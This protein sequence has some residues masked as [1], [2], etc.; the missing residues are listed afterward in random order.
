MGEYLS[1]PKTDKESED[2]EGLGVH[3]GASAM[4]GWRVS[5]EDAH[6]A[7]PVF[8]AARG[9]SL[10]A[11]FDGHGGGAVSKIVAEKLPDM[12]RK[13]QKFKEGQYA[14]ALVACFR[15][16]DAY[17][18]STLGRSHV[19]EVSVQLEEEHIKKLS[20]KER[21]EL[22]LE[23]DND[24]MAEMDEDDDQ[25][26]MAE[27]DEEDEQEAHVMLSG[28]VQSD[29]AMDDGSMD[30]MGVDDDG[31]SPDGIGCTA[32]VAL[33]ERPGVDAAWR[34]YVANCGD[35]R[36]VLCDRAGRAIP[37]SKDHKPTHKAERARIEAAGGVVTW[38]GRIDGNLNLSRALGDFAYKNDSKL[39]YEAQKISGVPDIRERSLQ[40]G[41]AFILL[42]CDG[43]WETRN[44]Q[45]TVTLLQK[46]MKRS[47]S[48]K[49]SEAA[50]KLLDQ[51]LSKNP[52]LTQGRGCDNMTA[53][54]VCFGD[55]M[56]SSPSIVLKRPASK[57]STGMKKIS[58]VQKKPGKK[59]PIGMKVSGVK[60]S[61][62]RNTAVMK[63]KKAPAQPSRAR[64]KS[65]RN[66]AR[67]R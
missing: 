17:L 25:D 39:A 13:E 47:K 30:E 28:G 44:N 7:L 35:A 11:V 67:R 26:D 33:I 52:Q 45:E 36:C 46:L 8:D 49:L 2:G 60:K 22:Q 12:L 29:G 51:T 16:M 61:A 27:V 19:A 18:N 53:M 1:K 40:S 31:H 37:M 34:L 10:F 5:Q 38:E 55:A 63:K 56:T 21:A 42:G 24:D 57:T 6:V 3:F 65:K 62:K 23:I 64:K 66:L 14:D 4:Q 48:G 50:G 41:D 58:G 59:S 9:L 15:N 32:I 54:L 20:A 43:I